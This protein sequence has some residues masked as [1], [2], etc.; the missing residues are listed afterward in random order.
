MAAN[1]KNDLKPGHPDCDS[2]TLKTVVKR[3]PTWKRMTEREF[4]TLDLSSDI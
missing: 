3:R 1:K 4:R 2:S